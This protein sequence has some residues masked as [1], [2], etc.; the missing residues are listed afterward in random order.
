MG[1]IYHEIS[2]LIG[3]TPL[4]ELHRME[5]EYG[6]SAH[7]LA[8]LEFYNPTC[9]SKDRIALNMITAAE[10]EGTLK[11][12]GT[13]MEGTSGNTG[14]G[15]AALGASKGYKV[16]ICMPDNM[17]AERRKILRAFGAEIYLTPAELNMAG[18]KIKVDE[19][20]ADAE[21]AV[22]PWQS[23]NIHNPE[24]HYLTTGPE[25]W[26]DTD[27]K[28]DILVAA[29]G[30]GGTICGTAR[31]LREK[32]PDLEVI[33][34][35]PKGSAVLSGG[36]AG[37]HKIQGIGGGDIPPTTSPE[38][39]DEII[40][41]SDDDAYE[42]ARKTARTEG[43]MIGISA[44]AALWAALQVSARDV[45]RGKNIVV[46]LPDSGERYLSGDLYDY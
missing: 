34:V 21:N 42:T 40:A 18:T 43:V 3:H 46:I 15:I 22:H 29:C 6:V 2:E 8:K 32:N 20:M 16:V 7:I 36:K 17:S 26:E 28:T 37:P 23:H 1:R 9:S 35:E 12:G 39:F 45:N 44:G 4:L 14:I 24:A 31:Y 25:I 13:I 19:L 41:V 10:R 33:A 30:T 38:L 11:P 5:K 27:G